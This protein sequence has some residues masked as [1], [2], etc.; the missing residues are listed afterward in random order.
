MYYYIAILL[1]MD[2]ITYIKWNE[3]K[4]NEIKSDD[5][6]KAFMITNNA[7]RNIHI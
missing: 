2:I 7:S 5:I 1:Y 3:I 4:L 6:G